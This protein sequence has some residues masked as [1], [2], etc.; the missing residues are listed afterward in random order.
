[1]LS[2]IIITYCNMQYYPVPACLF[3]K[4]SKNLNN[5]MPYLSF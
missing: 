1:M 4:M 2:D 5:L 3:N